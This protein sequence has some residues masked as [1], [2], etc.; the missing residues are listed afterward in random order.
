MSLGGGGFGTRRQSKESEM[1]DTPPEWGAWS[2]KFWPADDGTGYMSVHYDD[3]RLHRPPEGWD[4]VEIL[5]EEE[6]ETYVY[7]LRGSVPGLPL[8]EPDQRTPSL[9][10]AVQAGPPGPSA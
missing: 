9:F 2:G 5:Q 1:S 4:L 6:A 10:L 7:R 3:E 8:T